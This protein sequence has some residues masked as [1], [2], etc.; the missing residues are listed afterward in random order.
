PCWPLLAIGLVLT[1]AAAWQAAS[2]LKSADD[3][4]NAAN[5]N[6]HGLSVQLTGVR[7]QLTEFKGYLQQIATAAHTGDISVGIGMVKAIVDKLPKTENHVIVKGNHNATVVGSGQAAQQQTVNASGGIGTIGGT[8]VNPTVNNFGAPPAHFT[9]TENVITPLG[10]QTKKVLEVHITTDRR[11][12]AAVI[13]MVFSDPITFTTE[14]WNAHG[15]TLKGA[16][17]EQMD[18]TGGLSRDGTTPIP[19]SFGVRINA[20][21]AFVPGQELVVTVE[22]AFDVHL[23]QVVEVMN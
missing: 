8:L 12:P 20:P 4:T 18:V 3:A 17:I 23:L 22:S 5:A 16:T 11:V 19:N 9:A 6:A 14:Y 15:P 1:C 13:G 2:Q 7:S 10:S 21:S